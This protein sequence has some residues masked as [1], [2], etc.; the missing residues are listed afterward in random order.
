MVTA[1]TDSG[2]DR[3]E[4]GQQG[5]AGEGDRRQ[6][7]VVGSLAVALGEGADERRPECG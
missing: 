1:R 2:G 3:V 6:D 5:D 7:G 4:G